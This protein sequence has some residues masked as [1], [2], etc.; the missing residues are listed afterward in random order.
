MPEVGTI[1][2]LGGVTLGWGAVLCTEVSLAASL[3]SP[4]FDNQKYLQTLA[5]IPRG[6]NC[7]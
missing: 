5:N 3:A 2:I 4:K 6:Q 7:P 1:D